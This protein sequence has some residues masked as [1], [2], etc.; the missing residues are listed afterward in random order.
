MKKEILLG[1]ILLLALFLPGAKF[2]YGAIS[3]CG[4][5]EL[6]MTWTDACRQAVET[7]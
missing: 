3:N 2:R 5:G 7:G 1:I 4:A 6:L